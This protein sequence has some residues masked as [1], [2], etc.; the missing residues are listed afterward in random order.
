MAT[1]A[2]PSKFKMSA[3]LGIAS[4]AV[5]AATFW[6]SGCTAE[7]TEEPTKDPIEDS[8]LSE[9][10]HSFNQTDMPT[11]GDT[12]A[13]LTT[14]KGTIKIHLLEEHAPEMVKNFTTLTEK[15]KYN[16]VLFHRVIK[17]FMIQTGDF[18]NGN[19]TGGHSYKGPGTQLEDELHIDL[20]HIRG[21]VSMANH[22]PNT[23]GSQFFIVHKESTYLDGGYSIFGQVF[24]GMDAVDAIAGAK[25]MPGDMPVEDII[26]ETIELSTYS[27]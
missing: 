15:G 13:I 22:G 17:D 1:P 9:T 4:A 18:I 20:S 23:N 21:A 26:I 7:Q 27:E 24:E 16:D 14:S 8:Y 2:C 19:G 5:L 6:L 25:T 10:E 12:I 3:F 11:Q